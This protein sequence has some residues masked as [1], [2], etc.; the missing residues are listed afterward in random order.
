[1]KVVVN[2]KV[3]ETVI[4]EIV[5]EVSSFHSVRIDEI[6]A[7]DDEAP[8]KPSEQMAT[9]LSQEKPPVD[10]ENYKPINTSEL[11]KASAAIAEKI[12]QDRVQKFYKQLKDLA[13]TTQDS[14]KYEHLSEVKLKSIVEY[15]TG[16]KLSEAFRKDDSYDD[17]MAML[18][19]P[20]AKAFTQKGREADVQK[21]LRQPT[22]LAI[23]D[24]KKNVIG[25]FERL[26]K[27]IEKKV[28][29]PLRKPEQFEQI[30]ADLLS[31]GGIIADRNKMAVILNAMGVAFPAKEFGMMTVNLS[32]ADFEKAVR[33]AV[34]EN[35][36]LFAEKYAGEHF[37]G[38][39]RRSGTKAEVRGTLKAEA[40]DVA[41]SIVNQLGNQLPE[42]SKI[43]MTG[44][45]KFIRAVQDFVDGPFS[46]TNRTVT[47]DVEG[48][49]PD[50]GPVK[51]TVDFSELPLFSDLPASVSAFSQ[52]P[53]TTLGFKAGEKIDT[54]KRFKD[55]IVDSLTALADAL[56]KRVAKRGRSKSFTSTGEGRNLASDLL[57]RLGGKYSGASPEKVYQHV[58]DIAMQAGEDDETLTDS[59]LEK[60]Q[61]QALGKIGVLDNDRLDM[62]RQLID[63]FYE[64][65]L[66]PAIFLASKSFDDS[67]NVSKDFKAKVKDLMTN[68]GGEGFDEIFDIYTDLLKQFGEIPS[69]NAFIKAYEKVLKLPE[70]R[71][72]V[73]K[74]GGTARSD[75]FERSGKS[76]FDKDTTFIF[77]LFTASKYAKSVLNNP[78][79]AA[80]FAGR[81]NNDVFYVASKF[82][83]DV[84]ALIEDEND[85]NTKKAIKKLIE[86]ISKSTGAQPKKDKKLKESQ[87]LRSI[88]RS[89]I[90]SR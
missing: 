43:S 64:N 29:A 73:E 25:M 17:A 55:L 1:M 68:L 66:D 15:V 30:K 54:V 19:L 12:P 7:K 86:L 83:D 37:M 9:Q 34:E 32:Q 47:V 67:T 88:I 2:K 46:D 4:E 90:K 27:L 28:G 10:D 39:A 35:F 77:N 62:R 33:S 74:L 78:K 65:F 23:E 3:L 18:D 14:K 24:V 44:L 82:G 75:V 50:A 84:A 20:G 26:F 85:Q 87:I 53:G 71:A 5:N 21:A 57:R 16:R 36:D 70:Y 40:D 89:T 80:L 51:V 8:I 41:L 56:E 59:D 76:Y 69:N 81:D 31:P 52:A 11:T 79:L 38:L 42:S 58:T 45:D 48:V 6:P 61:V 22:S 49:T 60:L 72:Y 13:Q 63:A